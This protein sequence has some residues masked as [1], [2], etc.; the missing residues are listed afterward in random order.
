MAAD[1]ADAELVILN[2]CTVTSSADD[3]V[4]QAVRRV[5]RENPAAQ[6]LIT[7]CYAQRAPAEVAALEGVIAGWWGIR[8]RRVIPEIVRADDAGVTVRSRWAISCAE[9]V[10]LDARARR[11]P[12]I[13]RG[14][15]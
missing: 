9:R 7:G 15:T 11:L 6:I 5:H 12:R 2:T 4:R 8:T 13:A 10:R 1:C 3:D 14:L